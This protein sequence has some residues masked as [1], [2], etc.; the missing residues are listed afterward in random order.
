MQKL[1]T[2][3]LAVTLLLILSKL[4][5]FI[6]ELTLAYQ[7][8]TS[9]IVDVYTACITLP[10]VLFAMYA[11]GISDAYI[12]VYMRIKEEPD[13]DAFFSNVLSVFSVISVLSPSSA[14][15]VRSGYPLSS[16]QDLTHRHRRF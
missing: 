1:S 13:R 11:Y 8:G 3:A 7:F 9:Y 10:S 15:L 14:L 16:P 6:R 5:G 2:S 12:P 4:L